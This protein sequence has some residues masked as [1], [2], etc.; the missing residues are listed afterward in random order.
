[1]HILLA[2]SLSHQ[3]P[4]ILSKDAGQNHSLPNAPPPAWSQHAWELAPM[5]FLA[6]VFSKKFTGQEKPEHV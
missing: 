6:S 3:Q 5:I 1:M 2:T 4:A